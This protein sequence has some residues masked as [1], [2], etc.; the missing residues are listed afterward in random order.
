MPH[1]HHFDGHGAHDDSN[2]E[3]H[4]SVKKDIKLPASGK[5][6]TAPVYM[7]VIVAVLPL[8]TLISP[9][10]GVFHV[11]DISRPPPEWSSLGVSLPHTVALLI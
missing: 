3:R 11:C 4:V 9:E 2:T 6:V 1:T 10:P 7:A 8:V 5:T